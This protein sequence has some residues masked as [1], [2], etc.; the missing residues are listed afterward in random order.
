[1]LILSNTSTRAYVLE[2]LQE[3]AAVQSLTETGDVKP[4]QELGLVRSAG[5]KPN[6]SWYLK[7]IS[8]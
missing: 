8:R 1:M 5:I 2:S 7:S 3:V 6:A 4:E